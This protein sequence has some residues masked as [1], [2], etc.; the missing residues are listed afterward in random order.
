V[1]NLVESR[2]QHEESAVVELPNPNAI[3]GGEVELIRLL[4]REGGV[5][6]GALHASKEVKSALAD[7]IR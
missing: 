6:I 7:R 5:P 3:F 4:D 1:T 2:R